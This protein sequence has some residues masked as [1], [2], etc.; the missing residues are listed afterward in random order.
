MCAKYVSEA[1]DAFVGA[2]TMDDNLFPRPHFLLPSTS[3]Y[4]GPRW[5]ILLQFIH[6]TT[7]S[8][9]S[10][11]STTWKINNPRPKSWCH[12]MWIWRFSEGYPGSRGY[13]LLQFLDSTT[14]SNTFT[15]RPNISSCIYTDFRKNVLSL[16]FK[17]IL[18]YLPLS[19]SDAKTYKAILCAINGW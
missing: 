4:P 7:I 2:K 12:L 14:I 5:N 8:N 1:G 6:S 10:T 18:K 15:I 16:W 9:T 11:T 13:I 17:Q 19:K 3:G